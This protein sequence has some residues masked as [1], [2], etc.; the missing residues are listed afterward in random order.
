ML[1]EFRE[2]SSN[3]IQNLFLNAVETCLLP[4]IPFKVHPEYFKGNVK[5]QS[6]FL[7]NVAA[8]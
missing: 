8:R 3:V 5:M 2:L 1:K 7:Q 6:V 4:V